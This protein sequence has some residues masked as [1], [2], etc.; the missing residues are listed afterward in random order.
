MSYLPAQTCLSFNKDREEIQVQIKKFASKL[1]NRFVAS[2]LFLLLLTH[3]EAKY[4][5]TSSKDIFLRLKHYTCLV[6]V[7]KQ[8]GISY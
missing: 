5:V 8:L 7:Q 6:K 3:F 1:L 2:E 4:K